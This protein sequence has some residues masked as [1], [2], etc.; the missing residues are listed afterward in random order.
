MGKKLKKETKVKKYKKQ[1]IPHP[2]MKKIVLNMFN[3]S[4]INPKVSS[5][6]KLCREADVG[7]GLEQALAGSCT[8]GE[9]RRVSAPGDPRADTQS[10]TAGPSRGCI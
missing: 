1:H 9:Q 2:I 10:G 7:A 8:P 4:Y 3:C 6:T 5:R